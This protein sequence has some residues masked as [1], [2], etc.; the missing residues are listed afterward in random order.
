MPSSKPAGA[1][2][3]RRIDPTIVT[4]F[5]AAFASLG[6]TALVATT[7]PS[8]VSWLTGKSAAVHAGGRQGSSGSPRATSSSIWAASAPG[9]VEP[10][11]GEV[12]VRPEASGRIVEVYVSAGEQVRAG[13]LLLRLRDDEAHARLVQ[14]RAE[15]AVRLGERDEDVEPEEGEQPAKPDPR[16]KEI[17][18][19]ADALAAAERAL[20]ESRMAFDKVYLAHRNGRAAAQDV[21]TARQTIELAKSEVASKS[22]ALAAVEAK[23]DA[24]LPTRLDSGLT[25]ARADLRLAEIAYENTRVRAPVDGTLLT[26]DT[27]TGE[28]ISVSQPTPLL[29]LGDMSALRV[30]AEV[31]ERDV[32]KISV[33]QAVIVRSNAFEGREFKGRVATIAPVVAAPGLRAQGPRKQL[34][35]EVL[36]VKIDLEGSP[37]LMP[38]MRVDVYFKAEQRVSAVRQ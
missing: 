21:S 8:D 35:V 27:R 10:K 15:A 28:T 1:D 11:G 38:G 19:A 4:L 16:M 9:R 34:D 2:N 30:N 23:P 26:F 14:A 5:A 29:V 31:Q 25:L 22:A 36:E 12:A 37:P 7:A 18:A 6:L 24:P 17:Q 33:G 13:D 3:S 32:P 20:H